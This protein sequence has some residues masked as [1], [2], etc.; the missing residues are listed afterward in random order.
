MLDVLHIICA[1]LHPGHLDIRVGDSTQRSDEKVK[2]SNHAFQCDHYYHY[3]YYCFIIRVTY[4][5]R[6]RVRTGWRQYQGIAT[7][8]Q[9]T[10]EVDKALVYVTVAKTIDFCLERSERSVL[11]RQGTYPLIMCLLLLH[12]KPCTLLQSLASLVGHCVT[13]ASVSGGPEPLA[14]CIVLMNC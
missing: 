10:K 3:Y 14:C 7:G 9:T 12:P 8:C 1:Q 4:V 5:G 2:I 6:M 11:T 13:G